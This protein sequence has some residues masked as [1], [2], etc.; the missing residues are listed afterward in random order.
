VVFQQ[1]ATSQPDI[2]GTPSNVMDLGDLR[3]HTD[4]GFVLEITASGARRLWG[5]LGIDV[6]ALSQDAVVY[7]YEDGAE[8]FH[9][10]GES[11]QVRNVYLGSQ[12]LFAIP[13]F[14][15]L[16]EAL[17]HY[18][19]HLVRTSRCAVFRTAWFDQN[20]LFYKGGPEAT[21]RRSLE[22]CLVSTLRG[23]AEVRPEQNVD[24]SHPVDIRVTFQLSNRVALLEIK[25]LGK[26]KHLDG[27]LATEYTEARARE[28]ATQLADYLDANRQYA[29]AQPTRGYLVV[30]DGRRRGLT[31]GS[32]TVST[33]DGF[34]YAD[35]EIAFDPEYHKT[36]QDFEEPIRMF[37]EP[38]CN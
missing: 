24:E 29:P 36:R 8:Y 32:E 21:I 18:R 30:V 34:H 6:A 20:R 22:L 12:S 26:S 10:K 35:Q 37:S 25:W 4:E 1:V 33:E 14:E 2:N 3:D 13:T 19:R 28:G 7:V 17:I 16:R 11:K 27:T 5:S 23:N 38:V 31:D 9:A 15:D